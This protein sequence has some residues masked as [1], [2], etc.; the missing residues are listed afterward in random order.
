MPTATCAQREVRIITTSKNVNYVDSRR[1][2]NLCFDWFNEPPPR[3]VRGIPDM[4]D[5]FDIG[6]SGWNIRHAVC[7]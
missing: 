4:N 3:G 6:E 1:D 7:R 5:V 2:E